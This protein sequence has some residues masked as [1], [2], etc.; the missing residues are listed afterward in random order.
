MLW[1]ILDSI[2]YSS[3]LFGGI[4]CHG[5]N[6]RGGIKKEVLLLEKREIGS[7]E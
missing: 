3:T 1:I 2:E 4:S 5:D 6:Q 7:Q